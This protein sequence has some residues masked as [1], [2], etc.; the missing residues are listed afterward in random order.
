MGALDLLPELW[1][2]GDEAMSNHSCPA[3]GSSSIVKTYDF[4][5]DLT[6]LKCEAC[7]EMFAVSNADVYI[8]GKD[9]TFNEWA[10][11]FLRQM[12]LCGKAVK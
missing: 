11:S 8:N 10:N 7:G 4:E 1:S 9:W 12:R 5:R 3:C 6:I 2:E